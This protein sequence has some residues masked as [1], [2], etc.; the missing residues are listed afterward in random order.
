MEFSD[1]G[2]HCALATCKELDFLPF[3]CEFCAR[4]FCLAHRSAHDCP[5]AT[6]GAAATVE[7]PRCGQ[8]VVVRDGRS[9]DEAVTL[10][11]DAGCP[12]MTAEVACTMRGCKN[13]EVI[14]LRCTGCQQLYCVAHRQQLDHAC[15]KLPPPTR[16]PATTPAA[17][18]G[19]TYT[20]R[21]KALM[22]GVR[23]RFA[24]KDP[25]RAAKL[26]RNR[27]EGDD[28]VPAE[29]RFYAEVHFP[30]A[31]GV[32]P[33]NMFFNDAWSTGK[34]LDAIAAA[35]KIANAN[36]KPGAEKLFLWN[37]ATGEK[38]PNTTLL[39]TLPVHGTVLLL[40]TVAGVQG[41]G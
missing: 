23:A 22:D 30:Y 38:L 31:S 32:E 7:C 20:Q 17:P 28:K 26:L 11:L 14:K 6:R 29:R 3:R 18:A 41:K 8:V 2:A 40:E 24:A 1:V 19:P 12:L 34:A 9:A 10:H 25:A 15:P 21:V 35:G 27:A 13:R 37:L 39:R 5:A 36:D 33:R 16:A 4:T